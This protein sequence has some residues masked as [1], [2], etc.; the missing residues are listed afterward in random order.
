[1]VRSWLDS[2]I[3]KVFS[4]LSNSMILCFHCCCSESC[5]G[6]VGSTHG[7]VE[8][9]QDL[10]VHLVHPTSSGLPRA[11]CPAL[12]PVALEVSKRQKLHSLSQF[13]P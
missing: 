13:L 6:R 9:G 3:F 10:W 4:N 8:G 2:M 11:E 12:R 1:M 7:M 5:L